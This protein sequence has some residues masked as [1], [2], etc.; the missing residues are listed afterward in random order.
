MANIYG[1]IKN[2]T[3]TGTFPYKFLYSC[4]GK[5]TI[6]MEAESLNRTEHVM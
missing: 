1:M 2:R 4:F 6:Q 5:N 3:G